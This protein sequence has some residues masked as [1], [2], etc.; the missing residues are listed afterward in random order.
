MAPPDPEPKKPEASAA[1]PSGD[2]AKA[3][4]DA[5]K[6]E[7]AIPSDMTMDTL[8]KQWEQYKAAPNLEETFNRVLDTAGGFGFYELIVKF[9]MYKEK[10]SPEK[11]YDIYKR[12]LEK[13]LQEGTFSYLPLR[14]FSKYRD[15]PWAGP[16]L[17]NAIKR[18]KELGKHQNLIEYFDFYK[19]AAGIDAEKELS[20]AIENTLKSDPA[21][22][23]RNYKSYKHRA[24]VDAIF[25]RAVQAVKDKD[26]DKGI[27]EIRAEFEPFADKGLK[28]PM[29][30]IAALDAVTA[31]P[32]SARRG[33]DMDL[34]AQVRVP[35]RA[36]EPAPE[37]AKI[38]DLPADKISASELLDKEGARYYQKY[39]N[40]KELFLSR[41]KIGNEAG[42]L[43]RG[44]ETYKNQPWAAEVFKAAAL[45]DFRSAILNAEL[46]ASTDIAKDQGFMVQLAKEKPELFLSRLNDLKS[47]ANLEVVFE[48][49][50]AAA[51]EI[52]PDTAKK[53]IED[54]GVVLTAEQKNELYTDAT[55]KAESPAP[56]AEGEAE[57]LPKESAPAPM[58][59][60]VVTKL[61]S[62]GDVKERIQVSNE[63]GMSKV[64]YQYG[65]KRFAVNICYDEKG[66][67][68]PGVFT[69]KSEEGKYVRKAFDADTV[70]AKE[71]D[72][73]IQTSGLASAPAPAAPSAPEAPA[74]S[75]KLKE[76]QPLI[77]L[78]AL[79]RDFEKY[80]TAPNLEAFLNAA[81]D[82]GAENVYVHIAENFEK[83]KDA[84]RE[85]TARKILLKA[86]NN[87]V[88]NAAYSWVPIKYFE[89]HKDVE[90]LKRAIEQVKGSDPQ[91]LVELHEFYKDVPAVKPQEVFDY[92][93]FNLENTVQGSRS[94]IYLYPKYSKT[95]DR[96]RADSIFREAVKYLNDQNPLV[97]ANIVED[98]E[99]RGEGTEEYSIAVRIRVATGAPPS[100]PAP[101]EP[102]PSEPAPA[103]P[104]PAEPAPPASAVPAAAP[105][106]SAAP[107][108]P[109]VPVAPAAAPPAVAAA[110]EAPPA[111]PPAAA[112]AP[113][114]APAASPRVKKVN[115]YWREHVGTKDENQP[116]RIEY[117]KKLAEAK[118]HTDPYDVLNNPAAY[119]LKTFEELSKAGGREW[120]VKQGDALWK[121][122]NEYFK[123][124]ADVADTKSRGQEVVLS[125]FALNDQNVNV[126]LIKVGETVEI[127]GGK[128]IIKGVDGHERTSGFLRKKTA[129]AVS[130]APP[131]APQEGKGFEWMKSQRDQMFQGIIDKAKQ[132]SQEGTLLPSAPDEP[133][134]GTLLPPDE[135]E[136]PADQGT[137]LPPP[138]PEPADDGSAPLPL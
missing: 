115:A 132:A 134:Q 63:E 107:A 60:E 64:F 83:I 25:S 57:V 40:A 44:F 102:A 45:Q 37:K 34:S 120:T 108:V 26:G 110:E 103:E 12:A 51:K 2:A 131:A 39:P 91:K 114:A 50:K 61:R 22:V 23:V 77:S 43:I 6:K 18:N 69:L 90:I 101:A 133:G 74:V 106:V 104:V 65:D 47:G 68:T 135:P 97:L 70:T 16:V 67:Y 66:K 137:P 55:A 41:V 71:I 5:L 27:E 72:V 19:D 38:P 80:K 75:E 88:D 89:V 123:K 112:T 54:A 87:S 126:D 117:Y 111:A 42:I 11:A 109:A 28:E 116:A 122:L 118:L 8:F 128:L 33:V 15:Q 4:L 7:I 78:I 93:I 21:F 48:A 95:I 10:F 81:V 124:E 62:R 31:K 92:A 119:G 79:F 17:G 96:G 35:E 76:I 53:T 14:E 99:G 125:L 84:L 136:E 49:A 46:W 82:K 138:E 52:G 58:L 9:D 56:P 20:D 30:L 94:L 29:D 98:L 129:P 127:S 24:D 59:T 130:A 36:L 86:M 105:A 73:A 1:A 113:P 32:G 121:Y 3:K 85:E 100:E 13:S